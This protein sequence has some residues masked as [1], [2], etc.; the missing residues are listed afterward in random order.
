MVLCPRE[1]IYF[2]SL[3]SRGHFY[4]IAKRQG[5]FTGFARDVFCDLQLVEW[6]C[7][8]REKGH[9]WKTMLGEQLGSRVR[10]RT[11]HDLQV[12]RGCGVEQRRLNEPSTVDLVDSCLVRM[13]IFFNKFRLILAVCGLDFVMYT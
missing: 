4:V 11:P 5:F 6:F 8:N 7:W 1:Q 12:E 13:G 9:C 3:H 10:Q 2:A